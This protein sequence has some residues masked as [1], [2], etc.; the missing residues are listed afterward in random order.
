MCQGGASGSSFAGHTTA[1]RAWC[2]SDFTQKIKRDG[3]INA[4][5]QRY[6]RFM[7]LA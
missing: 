2:M 1:G 7:D 5:Q 6:F 3:F 4:K